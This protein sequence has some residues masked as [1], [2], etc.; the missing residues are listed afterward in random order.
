MKILFLLFL[1]FSYL[2]SKDIILD[3]NE[4]NYLKN[5]KII[6]MCVDP[7]WEPFEKINKAGFHEGISA[8]I[9]KLISDKLN[10]TI[11]LIPTKLGMK[12]LLCQKIKN[13]IF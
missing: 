6:T 5:K 7:D 8:D 1:C 10:I 3:E 4:K 2:F 9:I 12:V 13:V 11:K